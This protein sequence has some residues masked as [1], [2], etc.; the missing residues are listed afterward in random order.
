MIFSI[1]SWSMCIESKAA[2]KRITFTAGENCDS[3]WILDGDNTEFYPS[4]PPAGGLMAGVPSNNK[5]SGYNYPPSYTESIFSNPVRGGDLVFYANEDIPAGSDVVVEAV[6]TINCPSGAMRYDANDSRYNL[7]PTLYSPSGATQSYTVQASYPDVHT[8]VVKFKCNVH[9]TV[10]TNNLKW[11]YFRFCFFGVGAAK[12][13]NITYNSFT[14]YYEV[15]ETTQDVLE[16]IRNNTKDSADELKE[17]TETQK[18]IFGSIKDFFGSFFQNLIDSV[19]GLF[20]PSSDEMSD[21]FGQLN[22][23]FSDTFG[24]LYAPFDYLIQLIGVFTSST[25][26]TGLT[27]PGFSIMGHEVWGDQT[28]DISSDPVAGQVLGYVRIGTGV[29]LAGWFIMY[30]QDFFKERFGKG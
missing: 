11:R 1:M 27:L 25:G 30:L 10:A 12:A 14:A 17:Q 29:L 26:T 6:V 21:L 9:T 5:W 4:G 22:D 16:D 23:F 13:Y 7:T 24:F 18:G 19:I 3:F 15:D 8:L 28:Y 2:K 20:V